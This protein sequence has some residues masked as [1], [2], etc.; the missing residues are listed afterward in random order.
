VQVPALDAVDGRAMPGE[1][2]GAAICST[3]SSGKGVTKRRWGAKA[4]GVRVW[5]VE[6]MT[7]ASSTRLFVEWPSSALRVAPI[8]QKIERT[9]I[10]RL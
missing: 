8:N 3:V 6:L 5:V 7:R 2:V 9:R 1:P 4:G 10:F